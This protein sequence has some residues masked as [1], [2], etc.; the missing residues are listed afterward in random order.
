MAIEDVCAY[1]YGNAQ[2]IAAGSYTAVSLANEAVDTDAFHSAGNPTRLTVPSTGRYLLLGH[3]PLDDGAFFRNRARWLVNGSTALEFWG[4]EGF[5]STAYGGPVVY[6]IIDLAAGD[7]VELQVFHNDD[8]NRSCYPHAAI[9]KVDAGTPCC[10]VITGTDQTPAQNVWTALTYTTG[11]E[12]MDTGSM[13]DG[14]TNPSRLTVPR[15]GF[16]L[17]LASILTTDTDNPASTWQQRI[18]KNGAGAELNGARNYISHVV[19]YANLSCQ[20]WTV[21]E[22]VAGDYLEH[23]VRASDATAN[24]RTVSQSLFAA[25]YL[26]ESVSLASLY[27]SSDESLATGGG[28][29]WVAPKFDSEWYDEGDGHSTTTNTERITLVA[30]RHL[31]MARIAGEGNAGAS[32]N[33][34]RIRLNGSASYGEHGSPGRESTGKFVACN[35]FAIL[36][37]AAND[38][39]DVQT[40]ETTVAFGPETGL[41]AT[42]VGIQAGGVT[43]LPYLGVGP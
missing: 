37:A 18:S 42:R 33:D 36:D 32:G 23:E 24:R 17:V 5:I 9:A 21:A 27:N 3:A 1:C 12:V 26:G 31:V 41:L 16:Y 20:T 11:D 10:E 2:S 40:K 15:N 39:V 25:L 14:S 8:T 43:T 4:A 6:R 29:S 28:G 30:G 34:G 22:L 13:H 35:P 38:Y 19:G 7:Y